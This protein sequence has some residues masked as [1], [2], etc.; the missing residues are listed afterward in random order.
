LRIG[1]YLSLIDKDALALWLSERQT[2]KGGFNGRPEKLPDVCYSWWV[3][4][5]FLMIERDGFFDKKGLEEYIMSCQD[6]EG[7]IGDKPGNCVDVFHSFFG[8]AALS[9]LDKGLGLEE[10][11]PTFALPKKILKEKFKG[12]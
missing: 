1:G 12:L 6:K 2:I 9:M 8:L 4:S 11:D 3:Y 10:I 5:S 7:G